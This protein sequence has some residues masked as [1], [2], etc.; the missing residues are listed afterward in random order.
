[1]TT[2]LLVTAGVNKKIDI[3]NASA[4]DGNCLGLL[5]VVHYP[6]LR[7]GPPMVVDF[8]PG[9]DTFYFSEKNGTVKMNFTLTV[10]HRLNMVPITYL[11]SW[12]WKD[13]FRYTMIS[14]YISEPGYGD[15]FSIYNEMSCTNESWETYIIYITEADQL[16]PLV[17]NGEQKVLY[18]YLYVEAGVTPIPII[19]RLS[20]IWSHKDPLPYGPISITIIPIPEP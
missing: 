2:P 10:K 18:F 19:K 3:S 16:E 4:Y 1:M 7:E 13:K 8:Y 6:W 17:T 9:E 14:L 12:I 20:G 11:A 5:E 15:L